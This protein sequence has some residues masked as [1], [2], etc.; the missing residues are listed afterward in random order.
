MSSV[1]Q[2]T[3]AG[4]GIAGLS[5]ALRLAERGYRVKVYEP[6][7]RLGGTSAHEPAPTASNTTCTRTCT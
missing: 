1:P 6:S 7:D 4:G 2:V 3:V 5:A